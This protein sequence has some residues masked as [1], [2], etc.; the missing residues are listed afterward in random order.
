MKAGAIGTCFFS[1]I[2][3][4]C[5]CANTDWGDVGEPPTQPHSWPRRQAS[6]EIEFPL[7][8]HGLEIAGNDIGGLWHTLCV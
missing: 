1:W 3:M 7:S 8:F 6:Q 5:P 2:S 4:C